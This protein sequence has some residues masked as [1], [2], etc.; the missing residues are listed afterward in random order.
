M[1]DRGIVVR[2]QTGPRILFPLQNVDTES[3]TRADSFP[4]CKLVTFTG[5][6]TAGA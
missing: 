5:D 4:M 3:V 1:E 6:K 2:F